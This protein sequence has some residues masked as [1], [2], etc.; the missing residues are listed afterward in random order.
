MG[1]ILSD[2]SPD[3]FSKL[4]AAV[5]IRKVYSEFYEDG[6]EDAVILSVIIIGKMSRVKP[7]V[8][9]ITKL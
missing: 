4:M 1:Q 7:L 6:H 8:L 3:Q 2:W 5:E 9:L